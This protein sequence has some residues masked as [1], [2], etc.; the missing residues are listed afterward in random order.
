[1]KK[2]CFSLLIVFSINFCYTQSKGFF[3]KNNIIELSLNVQNP[4]VYNY[5]ISTLSILE[6]NAAYI[7]KNNTLILGHPKINYGLK[8]SIGRMIE[9]NLGFYLET[10]LNYFSVVPNQ[11]DNSLFNF[12]YNE[13]K[14]SNL[15]S[16]MIKIQEIS[17]LPK[18]EISSKDGL[19]PIGISNQF[20]FGFKYYKP[21]ERDYLGTVDFNDDTSSVTGIPI[22]KSNYY[23]YTNSSIKGYTLLYKLTLRIPIS[24]SLLF[25]FGFRYTF[26][27]VPDFSYI[28]NQTQI[29]SQDNMRKMIKIKENRNLLNFETG[30]SYC[31]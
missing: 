31:F 6:A 4:S 14:Y 15:I 25:H 20:G 1:M 16:E 17:I 12:S 10:G 29:I 13:S 24:K 27:F 7:K 18:I 19:L 2:F 28:S 3:G 22:S 26:N 8:L 30:I 5:K 9:R 11:N 23:K 21:I